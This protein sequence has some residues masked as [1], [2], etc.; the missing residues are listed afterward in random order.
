MKRLLI[1]LIIL[2]GTFLCITYLL[3]GKRWNL[4][5]VYP[6]IGYY[7]LMTLLV[8]QIALL[9]KGK[10]AST[11]LKAFTTSLYLHL[12]LSLG[13][14]LLWLIFAPEK[15]VPFIISYLLM[16]I[17]YT[18][19]EIWCLLFTLQPLSKNESSLEK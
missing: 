17:F 2:S 12:F 16:Y 9:G 6:A 8:F 15:N 13:Y 18:G 11:F 5:P 10:K 19:L 4:E 14:L 1:G 3:D 7:A